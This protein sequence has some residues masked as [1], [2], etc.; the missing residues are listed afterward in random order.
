MEPINYD[1][2]VIGSGPAGE[3]GAATA[4]TFGKKVAMVEKSPLV[5][6]ASANTGTIPS[7]T[8]RET[9]LAISGLRSRNLYGVDLS[10]RREATVTD[11]MFHEKT[12]TSRERQRVRRTLARHDVVLYQGAASFVDPHTVRVVPPAVATGEGGA[13]TATETGTDPVVTTGIDGTEPALG[14]PRQEVWLRGKV[15]LIATGS[16]PV[17]PSLFP[18]DQDRVHDSDE[19]LEL[20]RLPRSLAVVGAGV[21][22]S[23]YACTFAALGAKV[24]MIDG[25]DELL[26]FLDAEVSRALEQAMRERLGIEFL[27]KHRVTACN[28]VADGSVELTLDDDPSQII[29]ADDVLVA[30]GRSSNTE[31]LNL[32]AAGITPGKRGLIKVDA[33][34]RTTVPHI[35]AAGDV[36]GFP[37]LASTSMEQARVAMCHAFHRGYKTA[38]APLIPTGVYTI[39]EIGMVG[40]AEEDLRAEGVETVVGRASYC[41]NA[42]GQIV[43]DR[44]G[45]LKLIFRKEDMKLLG[46]HVLGDQAS[47]LVHIGVIA[48]LTD[49]TADLLNRACF[50]Y[51]TLGDLYKDAVYDALI[52]RERA[53]RSEFDPDCDH[54]HEHDHNHPVV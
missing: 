4:A 19:I 21:I 22:G 20:D 3:N 36:I 30:A 54:E 17:Q 10:I 31:A 27:W 51:P 13:E 16:S 26:P 14:G 11:F 41:Q 5:G 35:Y 40:A 32:A 44:I 53:R 6:G 39:P 29:K 24:L 2:I 15:I 8:L 33:S 46:V 12:V 42:R 34:Y 37:A 23:E 18:F 48:M 7:K 50:N 43:G 47:E 52:Q 45:F 38:I 49:S 28:V 9:A 1:L 25:R